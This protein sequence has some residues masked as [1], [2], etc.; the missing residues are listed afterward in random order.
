MGKAFTRPRPRRQRFLGEKPRE[1]HLGCSNCE[2]R[3][4]QR[5]SMRGG[6]I[7]GGGGGGQEPSIT[8]LPVGHF[9]AR[10]NVRERRPIYVCEATQCRTKVGTCHALCAEASFHS[11]HD[12]VP[13]QWSSLST[14]PPS[15]CNA[16]VQLTVVDVGYYLYRYVDAVHAWS[17]NGPVST[18][19][20]GQHAVRCWARD[21]AACVREPMGL[22][23]SC[24]SGM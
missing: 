8:C 23:P 21:R 13:Y 24:A 7:R 5:V 19:N 20:V 4:E 11:P 16:L 17:Y 10:K 12:T 14:R 22:I 6:R 2:Q 9:R 18:V 15:A 1:P 3:W